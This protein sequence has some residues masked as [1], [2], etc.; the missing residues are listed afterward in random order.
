MIFNLLW[1]RRRCVQTMPRHVSMRY[2]PIAYC[3]NFGHRPR[4]WLRRCLGTHLGV[5]LTERHIHTSMI[6]SCT[7]RNSKFIQYFFFLSFFLCIPTYYV[8][9][10]RLPPA[11]TWLV[12]FSV[13]YE[14]KVALRPLEQPYFILD[15]YISHC[16]SSTTTTRAILTCCPPQ[17]SY[18]ILDP[19]KYISLI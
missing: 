3:M 15:L 12:V 19:K 7:S 2:R 16:T 5:A 8:Q 4:L 17:A 18:S 14:K 1:T 10:L 6:R 13:T 11:Y 9:L